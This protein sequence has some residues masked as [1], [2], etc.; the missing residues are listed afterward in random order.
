MVLAGIGAGKC[1]EERYRTLAHR[2]KR[3]PRIAFGD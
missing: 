3:N 2:W 1:F